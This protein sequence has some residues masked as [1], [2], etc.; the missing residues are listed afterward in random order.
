MSFIAKNPLSLPKVKTRPHVPA[1]GTRGLFPKE[2]GWYDINSDGVVTK[3]ST[4]RSADYYIGSWNTP[5]SGGCDF[6]C[7][8]E[9]GSRFNDII[10][11]IMA[12][13]EDN[14]AK[15]GAKIIVRNGTYYQNNDI[16]ITQKCIMDFEKEFDI[17]SEGSGYN[18][19]IRASSCIFNGFKVYSDVYIYGANNIFDSCWFANKV[20]IGGDFAFKITEDNSFRFCIFNDEVQNGYAPADRESHITADRSSFNGCSFDNKLL[21]ACKEVIVKNCHFNSPNYGME[22][23]GKLPQYLIGHFSGNSMCAG[24]VFNTPLYDSVTSNFVAVDIVCSKDD[25]DICAVDGIY[26]VIY[27]DNPCFGIISS[28]KTNDLRWHTIWAPHLNM[29]LTKTTN[30]T[31]GELISDYKNSFIASKC[32]QTVTIKADKWEAENVIDNN[33]NVIG[34]RYGQR[35]V[36]ENATITPNSKVDLQISSEQAVIFRD[37]SLAFV[38]ENDDGVVTIYCVG[39]IPK[40]DYTMQVTVSEVIVNG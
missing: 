28:D 27:Q 6:I 5:E 14:P 13:M 20:Y 15:K 10:D 24:E 26:K 35:V 33:G 36:V 22:F 7:R 9:D 32:V 40:N 19:N 18:C 37:K 23:N 2:D 8:D 34:V 16:N 39:D 1:D 21:L 12:D 31:T 25:F 4:A 17:S 3:I 11:I 30:L 29:M 38:A